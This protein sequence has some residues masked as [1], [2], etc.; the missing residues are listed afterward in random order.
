MTIDASALLDLRR[1]AL[2]PS[3]CEQEH[4]ENYIKCSREPFILCAECMKGG[5]G[6]GSDGKVSL[7]WQ[8]LLYSSVT[9]GSL[10]SHGVG[11]L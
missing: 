11:Y 7:F 5:G 2:P 8:L 4:R 3:S 9:C 6:A 10:I 1:P